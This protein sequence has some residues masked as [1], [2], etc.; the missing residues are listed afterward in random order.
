M[1]L[2]ATN[3]RRAG[4]IKRESFYAEKKI[5]LHLSEAIE[6]VD[7]HARTLRSAERSLRYDALFLCTGSR[8]VTLDV[9][10]ADLANVHYL[11]GWNDTETIRPKI[12]P[13][14]R[15]VVIGGG[16]IG[17]EVAAAARMKD[18]AVTVFEAADEVLARV[19]DPAVGAMVR[20]FHEEAGV[21]VRR[22]ARVTRL[23]GTNAVAAVVSE[24]GQRTEA[25]VVVIG[26]GVRAEV[27]LARQLGIDVVDGIVVDAFGRTSVPHVFA[28]GDV[29]RQKNPHCEGTVRLESWQNAQFQ[30]MAAAKAALGDTARPHEMVPWFWSDQG[31]LNLQMLGVPKTWDAVVV[32]GDGSKLPAS[33]FYLRQKRG[34]GPQR[35]QRARRRSAGETV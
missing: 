29:T 11:R 6:D 12:R 20:R 5:E 15:V 8:L 34:G 4:L 26:I 28:A 2:P 17:L 10:G 18:A 27:R 14:A 19:V 16:Y 24:D 21:T 13:G 33:V 31:T 7:H 35:S 25:D 9:P 32:R 3:P 1:F 23:E 22:G 30:A